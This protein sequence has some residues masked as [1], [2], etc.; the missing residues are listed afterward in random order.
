MK[1][2]YITAS[3][4]MNL[5]VEDSLSYAEK[6]AEYG[7]KNL[8]GQENVEVFICPDFLTLYPLSNIFKDTGFK[9]GALDCFWEDKGSYTG[10]ISPFYLKQI[11]CEYVFVGHLER[12]KYLKE[13]TDIINKKIKA[14]LRND[15][16]P[17]LFVVEMEKYD[18][19]NR[20]H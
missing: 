7:K 5:S 9:M 13:D 6:L 1:K 2:R 16:T 12:I 11:G 4:K 15:L 18:D 8:E 19:E 20:A 3:W 17:V 10:E 14:C